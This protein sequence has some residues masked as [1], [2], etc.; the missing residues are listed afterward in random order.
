[1]NKQAFEEILKLG[2]DFR[3]AMD[4]EDEE[5]IDNIADEILEKV[6]KLADQANSAGPRE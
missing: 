3:A 5:M 6:L 4:G 1:M 2:Q